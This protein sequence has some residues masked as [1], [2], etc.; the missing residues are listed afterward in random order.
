MHGTLGRHFGTCALVT[1]FH[2]ERLDPRKAS[3]FHGIHGLDHS[4]ERNERVIWKKL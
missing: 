4:C 3:N 1:M 2:R